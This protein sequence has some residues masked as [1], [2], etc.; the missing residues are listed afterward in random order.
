MINTTLV[1]RFMAL[2]RGN[3]RSFGQWNPNEKDPNKNSHTKKSAYSVGDVENHF[4]GVTGIGLV[5]IMDDSTCYW[6][7]I[8]IDNHG[9]SEDVDIAAIEARVLALK[10]PLI[11]CR[12][13]SGGAHLYLFG[14][15][16]L[17]CVQVH[18]MLSKWAKDLKVAGVDCIYPKQT[19]L[20]YSE[21][22][23]RQLG[24]WINLPYFKAESTVRYAVENGQ[25]LPLELF[26][27]L[28]ES[29]AVSS[30]DLDTMHGNEHSEAPPCIAQGIMDGIDSGSRNEFAYNLTI[31]MRRRFPEEYRDRIYDMNST[32]FKQPL[33]FIEIKKVVQSA[34]RRDYR[35]K[36]STEPCKSMCDR[37]VC[38]TRKFGITQDQSDEIDNEFKLPEFGVLS[39]YPTNPVR[40]EMAVEGHVIPLSTEELMDWRQVRNKL[41]ERLMRMVPM[42][43]N[44]RWHKVLEQLIPVCRIMDAP[45]DASV[46][47]IIKNQLVEFMRK[48]DLSE[49]GLDP[50][51][52]KDIFRGLPVVQM[53][54]EGKSVMFRGADFTAFLKRN[55]AEELKGVNLWFALKNVGVNHGRFRVGDKTP[56]L[57]FVSVSEED[58]LD[59]DTV[60]FKA[61]F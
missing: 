54:P 12:S 61:E 6:G 36:C 46:E 58:Q 49:D 27:A 51:R 16:P 20:A 57:W 39:K 42:I 44:D 3:P 40:W 25:P 10:L 14:R 32:I 17:R 43:K 23:G 21:D 34:S 4:N 37:K 31:Y 47:G 8:D 2:F 38:L 52:R 41:V 28:A 9:Q 11:T 22:G 30:F 19:K 29:R 18:G 26:L 1:E 59:I 33:P 35:Y 45:E 13:K 50:E 24:N 15:E 60:N 48:V 56:N 5:P 55:K 53:L 7:A